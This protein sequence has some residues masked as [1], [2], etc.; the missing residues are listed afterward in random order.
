MK[1][2][3]GSMSLC[4]VLLTGACDSIAQSVGDERALPFHVSQHDLEQGKVPVP[5]LIDIGRYLFAA[6]FTTLDGAGRPGSTGAG[7]PTRR[8]TVNAKSFLRTSGPD[9]NA[10]SSCHNEPAVGGAGSFTSNVF[11]GAQEREPTLESVSSAFSAERKSPSMFGAGLIELLARE[12][13]RE[14]HAIRA[15]TTRMA[16]Q[17]GRRVSRALSTKGVDFGTIAVEANGT[18]RTE[19]IVGVDKDLVVRPWSQKGVVTSLRTF[20]VTAMNHHHGIQPVERFGMRQTGSRDFD[21][22]GIDDEMSEGDV[23]AVTLFQ[24][25]L[26]APIVVEPEDAVRREAAHRGREMFAA[27]DCVQCH[28]AELPLESSVFVEPGPYNLEGT[29]R[30]KEV[31]KTVDVDL[32]SLPWPGGLRRDANG[33]LWVAAF[34][35]LKRHRIADP[36]KPIFANE[37]VSQGFS[38]TDEF[39]TKRLWEVGSSLGTFG[40]RGDI[41]TINDVILAHGGEARGSRRKYEAAKAADRAAVIEFMR[42]LQTPSVDAPLPPNVLSADLVKLLLPIAGAAPEDDLAGAVQIVTRAQAAARRAER[43]LARIRSLSL[44]IDHE[45]TKIVRGSTPAGTVVAPPPPQVAEALRRELQLVQ[46]PPTTTSRDVLI[47]ALERAE[48]AA[49]EA[50]TA[51]QSALRQAAIASLDEVIVTPTGYRAADS[52]VES[53][54]GLRERG[55]YTQLYVAIAEWCEDLAFRSEQLGQQVTVAALRIEAF[56]VQSQHVA[57]DGG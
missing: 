13:T 53:V 21:R 9:A 55:D 7:I 39:L 57:R 5:Q 32:A 15:D 25:T 46:L 49:Q 23:T 20:T 30:Q 28:V 12:M 48:T 35:D 17:Q 38:S 4:V 51:A 42:T 22:D 16:A 45:R 52:V 56:A 24:A 44:R 14:L 29:L 1:A 36:E 54:H 43:I 3:I 8:P 26:P 2:H 33:R 18:V 27:L 6:K 19:G 34:T 41:T 37:V 50:H 10:C 40:H 31:E 11:V 47:D